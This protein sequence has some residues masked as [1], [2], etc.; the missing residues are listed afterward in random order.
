[1][2]S[3]ASF[4]HGA[5][6]CPGVSTTRIGWHVNAPRASVYRALLDPRA[7]AKERDPSSITSLVAPRTIK[8]AGRLKS[9]RRRDLAIISQTL[10]GHVFS[11]ISASFFCRLT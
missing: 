10:L 2:A 4:W 9:D 6:Y 8:D 5:W 11:A 1:M 3:W 7:V